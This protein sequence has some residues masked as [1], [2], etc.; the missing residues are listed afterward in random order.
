MKRYPEIA[1][2]RHDSSLFCKLYVASQNRETDIENFFAHENQRFP[3]SISENGRLRKPTNKSDIIHCLETSIG[4]DVLQTGETQPEISATVLDGA[5]IV[6]LLVPRNVKT[7]LEYYTNIF[8]PY[9]CRLFQNL[10]RIDLVFDRYSSESLKTDTRL[11]RG[12][13]VHIRVTPSTIIP[14]KYNDFLRVD[15]NKKQLFTFLAEQLAKEYF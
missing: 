1:D 10:Q 15:E 5:V 13:G 12:V 8:K 4:K 7:F 3:P 2:L 6:H 9:I 11:S 14:Q